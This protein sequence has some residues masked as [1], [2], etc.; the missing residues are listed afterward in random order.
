MPDQPNILFIFPDQQR[1]DTLGC[2][3]HPVV[4]TPN[5]DKMAAEGVIFTRCYTNSPLCTPAR[6]SLQTGRYVSEHGAWNNQIVADSQSPSFVRNLRDA[7]YHTAIIG[8]SHLWR[9]GMG[10]P[11]GTHT[12]DKI[13]I[14]RDWGFEDIHELTGPMA[15]TAHDSPYT[16]YLKERGLLKAYRGYQFEYLIRNYLLKT[17][18]V[19]PP[20]IQD[21]MEEYSLSIDVNNGALWDDPPL[22]LPP[23][24][25]YDSYV[26]Q[27]SVDWVKAYDQEKPFFLMVGF[28]GPHDP[29]DSPQA[30]R[31]LYRP[32]DI[33]LGIMDYPEEPI[34]DYLRRLLDLSG[35]KQMTDSYL[36]HMR[37]AYYGKVSLIDDYIGRIMGALEKRGQLDN[38]W[39][40][41]SSDHGELLGDHRLCHKMTYYEG[42]LHIPC[43]IRPAGGVRGW[44]SAGLTD[45]L[46]LT[47]TLLDIAGVEPFKHCDGRSLARKIA[48]GPG[49]GDAQKGRERIFS[50]LAGMA[51]VFD[52]RYK[53]VMEIKTREPLQLH[54]LETDHREL[55]NLVEKKSH[56]FIRRELLDNLEEHLSAHLDEE[57]FKRFLESGARPY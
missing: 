28:P 37:V 7:G 41:Y 4:R 38:T 13:P 46:D 48:A 1:G 24:D 36:Q 50:E 33:P 11:S 15:S 6:T 17:S 20:A 30:Y 27:K 31:D 18:R 53:L 21:L 34:P 16:D 9:H 39:I 40:I 45:H 12:N 5:L 32:E 49:S 25:H 8:K 42:A 3:G 54:D 2:V 19:I 22:P 57:K 23:E 52:G 56:E 10:Q 26:G 35:L 29:F 43:I 55:H 47:A 51:A 44:R 14:M